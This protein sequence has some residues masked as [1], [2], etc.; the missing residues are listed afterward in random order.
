[1]IRGVGLAARMGMLG[2]LCAH[3]ALTVAYLAPPSPLK[4][5]VQPLLDATVGTYFEQ[6]WSLFAPSPRSSDVALLARPLTATEVADLSRRGLPQEG[7]YDLSGPLYT[8]FEGNRLSAYERLS[9][10]QYRAILAYFA[11]DPS[12]AAW[13]ESCARGDP[14]SCGIYEQR[15]DLGRAR[16]RELLTHISS[17]FYHDI[18]RPGDTVTH[19]ALRARDGVRILW[20]QRE[21]SARTTR[22]I[23][24][25]V[26]PVDPSVR[27]AGLYRL[28]EGTR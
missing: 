2:L 7:W 16:A 4:A 3:F 1:L 20:S 19:V 24:L 27:P 18:A 21:T 11:G 15:V 12:L 22:D 23:D 14:T 26:Y 9:R 17:A 6:N 25:G 10:P 28:L 13:Q 8:A 5:R